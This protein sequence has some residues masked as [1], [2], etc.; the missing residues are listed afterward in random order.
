MAITP[1]CRTAPSHPAVTAPLIGA[2]NLDQLEPCL[3]AANIEMDEALRHEISALSA[4][5]APA[6]DRNE[7]TSANNYGS[8]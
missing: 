7:E 4:A 6:T 5:P 8:R 3:G 2:R 1:C